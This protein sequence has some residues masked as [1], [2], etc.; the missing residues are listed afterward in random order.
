MK[1]IQRRNEERGCV[2]VGGER[3]MIILFIL[4][5]INT[6]HSALVRIIHNILVKCA[7]M[8]INSNFRASGS[9]I[10]FFASTGFAPNMEEIK[11]DDR[12]STP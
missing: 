2:C 6:F 5:D 7:D 12:N 8:F 4:H 10:Y 11:N 9:G 3:E 1:C